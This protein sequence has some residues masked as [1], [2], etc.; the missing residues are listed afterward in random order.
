MTFFTVIDT[1]TMNANVPLLRIRISP[2]Y[3]TWWKEILC[4]SSRSDSSETH[5]LELHPQLGVGK[6]QGPGYG[7]KVVYQ[8]AETQVQYKSQHGVLSCKCSCKCVCVVLQQK[9]QCRQH[10][11]RAGDVTH[12]FT[13]PQGEVT[14][15]CLRDD[16]IN[17]LLTTETHTYLHYQSK[18][19]TYIEM[20]VFFI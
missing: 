11:H 6:F 2:K 16:V 13:E 14:G 8:H 20:T 18:V 3:Y 5:R 17:L 4:T 7:L 12:H 19:W 10:Y 15:H 1:T 9:Q